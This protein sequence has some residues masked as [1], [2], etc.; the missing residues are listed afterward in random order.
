MSKN[1]CATKFCRGITTKAGKSPYC[2]KCRS[3][4]WKAAHP[5]TYAYNKLKYRAIQRGKSFSLTLNEF[6]IFA[7]TSGWLDDKGKTAGS[8]SINRINPDL[9]Y[10]VGNIEAITL[11]ENS[12][13]ANRQRYVP[14]FKNKA[15]EAEAIKKVEAEIARQ[16]ESGF[17]AD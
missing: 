14:Y 7:K 17:Y 12:A 11:S 5:V 6:E 8:L 15:D 4:R 9:G 1:K 3:R 13:L 2:A 10:E 16:N